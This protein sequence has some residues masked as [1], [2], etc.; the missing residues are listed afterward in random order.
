[1]PNGPKNEK[2][3]KIPYQ[4]IRKQ[5]LCVYKQNIEVLELVK[6][7]VLSTTHTD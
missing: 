7:T 5:L 2:L 4:N 3:A 6:T 1:M